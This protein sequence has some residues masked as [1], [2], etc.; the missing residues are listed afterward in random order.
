[1]DPA[2]AHRYTGIS[3]HIPLTASRHPSAVPAERGAVVVL[4]SDNAQRLS[5][6]RNKHANRWV[7]MVRFSRGTLCFA[8]IATQRKNSL[9]YVLL[10]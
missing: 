3:T 7:A 10:L 4:V 1:M 8:Q 9:A 2:T 5:L 6:S